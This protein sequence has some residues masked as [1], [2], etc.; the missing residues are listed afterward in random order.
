MKNPP[1]TYLTLLICLVAGAI[2]A[3][4]M[5]VPAGPKTAPRA[6]E[7]VSGSVSAGVS[8]SY[9]FRGYRLNHK[10]VVIEPSATISYQ[11]FSLTLWDNFD[12][13]QKTSWT[14]TDHTG[15][16]NPAGVIKDTL[17]GGITATLNF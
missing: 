10:S 11:N 13:G 15:A 7:R 6:E 1:T 16:F 9:M 3:E 14:A 5:P 17:A 12:M 2:Y 4:E 8:S